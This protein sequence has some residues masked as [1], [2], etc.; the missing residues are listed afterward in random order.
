MRSVLLPEFES[1]RESV[2]VV[3]YPAT[4]RNFLQLLNIAPAQNNVVGF[5]RCDHAGYHVLDMSPPFFLAVLFQSRESHITLVRSFFVRQMS[6]FHRLDDAVYNKSRTEPSTEAEEQHLPALVTPQSLHGGVVDD[7]DRTP[8]C[9]SKIKTDPAA[10][11]IIGFGNRSIV[12]YGPRIANGDRVILRRPKNPLH[13]GDH[14]LWRHLGA[15]RKFARRSLPSC[16]HLHVRSAD[17]EH[18]HFHAKP[19]YPCNALLT[20]ACA[21]SMIAFKWA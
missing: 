9:S 19:S 12:E 11:Q 16:E 17:I 3:S 13:T 18:Q 20:I 2:G 15:R 14:L 5:K 21:S 6:E 4:R 1:S 7:L 8:E 10:S